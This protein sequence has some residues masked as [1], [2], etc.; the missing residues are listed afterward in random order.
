M[1][2]RMKSFNNYWKRGGW[3]DIYLILLSVGGYA[4]VIYAARTGYSF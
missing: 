4:A 3:F 1:K 2:Q